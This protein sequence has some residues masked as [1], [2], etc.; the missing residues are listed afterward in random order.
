MAQETGLCEA[1]YKDRQRQDKHEH[2][3][4]SSP[5]PKE[6]RMCSTTTYPSHPYSIYCLCVTL[7]QQKHNESPNPAMNPD[8]VEKVTPLIRTEV[9]SNTVSKS[10]N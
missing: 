9:H 1:E 2:E 4:A 5:P 3:A 6:K 7:M 10:W 8:A